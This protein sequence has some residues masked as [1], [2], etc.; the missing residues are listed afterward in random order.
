MD[1]QRDITILAVSHRKEALARA[2]QVVVLSQGQVAARGT[3][4]E[5]LATSEE[6]RRLWAAEAQEPAP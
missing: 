5:L 1:A 3:L 4:T 6:M 2:D